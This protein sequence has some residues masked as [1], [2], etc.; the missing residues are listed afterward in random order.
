MANDLDRQKVGEG[1]L[2]ACGDI[3]AHTHT[4]PRTHTHYSQM[5]V[6]EYMWILVHGREKE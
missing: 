5:Y 1:G 3:N 2:D 4:L 6:R